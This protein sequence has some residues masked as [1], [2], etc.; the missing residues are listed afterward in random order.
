MLW[1]DQ[2]ETSSLRPLY[3]I[4]DERYS[5]YLKINRKTV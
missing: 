5:V 1:P 3:E 4:T 2:Q